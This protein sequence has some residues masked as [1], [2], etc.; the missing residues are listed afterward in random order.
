[1]SSSNKL[2]KHLCGLGFS[3]NKARE[4]SNKAKFKKSI[5]SSSHI[6]FIKHKLIVRIIWAIDWAAS[7]G[8]YSARIESDFLENIITPW[9]Y[10]EEGEIQQFFP[11]F[12]FELVECAPSASGIV[13]HILKISW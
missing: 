1:M 4:L 12:T 2:P 10:F 5:Y 11:G 8:S 6:H 7:N 9:S 13:T 3:A